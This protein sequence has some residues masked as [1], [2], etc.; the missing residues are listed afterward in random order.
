MFTIDLPGDAFKMAVLVCR[1]FVLNNLVFKTKVLNLKGV[2]T[3]K[4][5]ETR[6]SS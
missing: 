5:K 4:S 1:S 3:T 6:S 2:G